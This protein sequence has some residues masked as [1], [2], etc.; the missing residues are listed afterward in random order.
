[1]HR[2]SFFGLLAS[3]I[4]ALRVESPFAAAADRR[5][6]LVAPTSDAR[7]SMERYTSDAFAARVGQVFAFHRTADASDAPTQLE[8]IDVQP[9]AHHAVAGGRRPFSLLFVSREGDAPRESTL[10]VRHDDFQPCGWFVSRVTAP[11]REQHIP[12]YEAV[13]G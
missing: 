10:H 12:H 8:L 1:M 11:Q 4:T 3:G 13:F 2:R 9:S 7:L 5:N 6:G